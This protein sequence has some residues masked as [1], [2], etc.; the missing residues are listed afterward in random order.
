MNMIVTQPVEGGAAT[1]AIADLREIF[2]R[3]AF[4]STVFA[5]VLVP[6]RRDDEEPLCGSCTRRS[7]ANSPDSAPRMNGFRNGI[8]ANTMLALVWARVT[9]TTLR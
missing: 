8:Q 9:K 2:R 7:L 3:G 5:R 1:V 6:N 4:L